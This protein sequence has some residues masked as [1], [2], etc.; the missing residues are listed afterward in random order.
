MCKLQYYTV[1]DNQSILHDYPLTSDQRER[2]KEIIRLF[3]EY[4]EHTVAVG[5]AKRGF[6]ELPTCIIQSYIVNPLD[7]R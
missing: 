4:D 1:L 2:V 5:K 3:Y 7:N 6:R